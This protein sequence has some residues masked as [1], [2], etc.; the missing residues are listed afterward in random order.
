[1][2]DDY[3]ALITPLTP[4]SSNSHLFPVNWL[5]FPFLSSPPKE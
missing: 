3:A 5:I 1:M 4:N 2:K